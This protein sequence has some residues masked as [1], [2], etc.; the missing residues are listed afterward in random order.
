MNQ[1]SP[2]F[3]QG[4][5]DWLQV[6]GIEPSTDPAGCMDVNATNYDAEATI[7]DYDEWGNILCVML[8]VMIF[9]ISDVF[10]QMDLELSMRF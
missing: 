8:H 4:T 9:L 10:M 2:N 3:Q 7:Q 6:R 1:T 5:W